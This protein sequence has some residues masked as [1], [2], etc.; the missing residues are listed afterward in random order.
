LWNPNKA[1]SGFIPLEK[2][3]AV[4]NMLQERRASPALLPIAQTGA[5][6][7]LFVMLA[8]CRWSE[9]AELTWDCVNLEAGSWH[10][11]DPKNHNPVTF[12][13][14]APM[15]AMLAARPRTEGNDYVFPG[16]SK[17]DFIKDARSTMAEVSKLAGLHLTHHDL[18]RTFIAIGIHLKI[19]MWKL[20]LLTNHISKGD[21]TI[22]HYTETGNLRY[23][24]GEAEQIAAWIVAQG[25][26]A[27][28]A[29]V[30]QL[31]E[32]AA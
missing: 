2:V 26:V 21:V 8:G 20:K 15:L 16:R 23:L 30:V 14:P 27:D 17:T 25:K 4:W 10:D 1:K 9:A 32:V 22:D 13:I 18:R 24:S 3:G 11:P 29:N 5:D 7:T 19:E 6:I 31:R 12:P 28:G